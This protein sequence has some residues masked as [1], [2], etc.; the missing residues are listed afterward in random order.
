MSVVTTDGG[1][2]SRKK[3]RMMIMEDIES[4]TTERECRGTDGKWF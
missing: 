4:E 1:S 3:I 2:S